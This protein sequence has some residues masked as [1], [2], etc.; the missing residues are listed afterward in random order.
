MSPPLDFEKRYSLSKKI[1]PEIFQEVTY[2][3]FMQKGFL[4]V[5]EHR[6]T[7]DRPIAYFSA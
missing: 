3:E 1:I 6:L 7:A 5:P 2:S 4:S